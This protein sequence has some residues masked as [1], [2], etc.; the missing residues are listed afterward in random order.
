MQKGAVIRMP[1][2]IDSMK[3]FFDPLHYPPEGEDFDDG[4]ELL[5]ASEGVRQFGHTFRTVQLP[6]AQEPDKPLPLDEGA[7]A[8]LA[9]AQEIRGNAYAKYSGFHVGAALLTASGK[10]YLGVNVENASYPNGCC[11][12]RSAV[13]AAITAG[14]RDFTAIAICGE[15]ASV[16]CYP[17]GMCR[18]VLAEFGGPDFPVIL[19]DGIYPLRALLPYTFT[20]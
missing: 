4:A 1:K 9:L 11:A 18:Q 3:R 5:H 13:S 6:S 16:P 7:A 19:A 12:E 8:L 2:F 17:C 10:V 14:E 20:L 15:P